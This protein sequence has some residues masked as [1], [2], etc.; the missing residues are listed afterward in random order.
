MADEKSPL[1]D[2]FICDPNKD[3]N[4]W[5]VIGGRLPGLYQLPIF[6]AYSFIVFWQLKVFYSN[7]QFLDH[8]FVFR[9]LLK[10]L[11][12]SG[13]IMRFTFLAQ[14]PVA[15]YPFSMC[16]WGM[17]FSRYEDDNDLSFDVVDFVDFGDYIGGA[18]SFLGTE[19]SY[20]TVYNVVPTMDTQFHLTLIAHINVAS[21]GRIFN[22]GYEGPGV[23]LNVVEDGSGGF[24]CICNAGYELVDTENC[25]GKPFQKT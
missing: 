20:M 18:A 9:M 17:D 21:V 8:K 19:S 25:G 24:E 22:Y 12:L 13:L 11:S 6:I 14:D 7:M 15:L 10:K 2:R 16:S 4:M 5:T 1:D 23:G 3:P